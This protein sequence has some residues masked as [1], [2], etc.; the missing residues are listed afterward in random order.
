MA[1]LNT[2][3]ISSGR[4]M[5]DNVTPAMK[6]HE[7]TGSCGWPRIEESKA[8]VTNFGSVAADISH[9]EILWLSTIRSTSTRPTLSY[10]VHD[11]DAR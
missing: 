10:F 5:T 4:L 6:Y 9:T 7:C 1:Y 8:G 11:D 2:F 3:G